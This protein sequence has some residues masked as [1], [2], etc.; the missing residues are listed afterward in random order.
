VAG[1]VEKLSRAES[2]AYFKSRPRGSQLAAWTSHQGEVIADRAVLEKCWAELDTQ[3]S[4]KEI[5]M[6]ACWGGYVVMPQRI[7][8]WQGR[9]SRLHD[10]FCYMRQADSTWR[11]ER[12]S[13]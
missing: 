12:L 10:R 1:A 8:F 9:P 5:P 2:E 4:G 11:L 13:P 7:E 3:Y 6:P